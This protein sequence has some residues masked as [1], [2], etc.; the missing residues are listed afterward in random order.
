MVLLLAKDNAESFKVYRKYT[1][2]KLVIC[3]IEADNQG[4]SVIWQNT[5]L[6]CVLKSLH[7]ELCPE[8]IYGKPFFNTKGV[9]L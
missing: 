6:G 7:V 3:N 4:K 9:K 1:C 2:F 8:P 5:R